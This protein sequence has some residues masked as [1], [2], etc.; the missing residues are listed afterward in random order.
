MRMAQAQGMHVSKTTTKNILQPLT[1][2]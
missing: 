2:A 1:K